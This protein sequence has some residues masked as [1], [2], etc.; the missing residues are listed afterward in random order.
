MNDT[1]TGA[2]LD[3]FLFRKHLHHLVLQE[4]SHDF[5]WPICLH[6]LLQPWLSQVQDGVSGQRHAGS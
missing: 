5:P 6:H 3:P 2:L 4:S 1:H